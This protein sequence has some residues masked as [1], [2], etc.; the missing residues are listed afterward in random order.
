MY[1][2]I[3]TDH[4]R[5]RV[6]A[7]NPAN[8]ERILKQAEQYQED[9]HI[10]FIPDQKE[11]LR[12]T[13]GH[14]PQTTQYPLKTQAILN[15]VSDHC[16]ITAVQYA[17]LAK[18]LYDGLAN[19]P[20]EFIDIINQ[21]SLLENISDPYQDFCFSDFTEEIDRLHETLSVETDNAVREYAK[22]ALLTAQENARQHAQ[23]IIDNAKEIMRLYGETIFTDKTQA[24]LTNVKAYL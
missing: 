8:L 3:A 6:I 15:F 14:L 9:A 12:Q 2:V 7:D 23:N 17:Y 20:Q 10:Q 5:T 4:A 24:Y 13:Y 19:L 16:Y 22:D 1:Y 21:T 18:Y 11:A